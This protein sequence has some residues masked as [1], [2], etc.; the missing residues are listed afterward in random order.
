M[1]VSNTSS[2][3]WEWEGKW[4]SWL[5]ILQVQDFHN[6]YKPSGEKKKKEK[7]L[8]LLLAMVY[9]VLPQSFILCLRVISLLKEA[10]T[11]VMN[12]I[13]WEEGISR[14][15]NRSSFSLQH[16]KHQVTNQ[17]VLLSWAIRINST[18]LKCELERLKYSRMLTLTENGGL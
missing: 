18:L 8:F 6:V 2:F 16:S 4:K 11:A 12:G 17:A 7:E 14:C 10:L 15:L 5:R 3:I 9:I 13:T 1:Q